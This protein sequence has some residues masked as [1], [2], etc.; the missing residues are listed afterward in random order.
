MQDARP[1]FD[2]IVGLMMGDVGLEVATNDEP[3]F[4]SGK[5]IEQVGQD[6]KELV[7]TGVGSV[8]RAEFERE[9]DILKMEYG[10]REKKLEE[11]TE[12]VLK[13]L[14]DAH[15]EK[16]LA[17]DKELE[18]LRTTGRIDEDEGEGNRQRGMS[19]EKAK[20]EMNGIMGMLGR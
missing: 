12:K 14:R 5:I 13:R 16:L 3:V 9:M 19:D 6:E 18:V 17:K 4:G 10:R 7:G 2:E 11:D 20:E 15:R 8:S 1:N